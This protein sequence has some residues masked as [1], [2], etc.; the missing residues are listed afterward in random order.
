MRS[1]FLLAAALTSIVSAQTTMETTGHVPAQTT[2]STTVVSV[3]EAASELSR[4]PLKNVAASLINVNAVMTT[5][6]IGCAPGAEQS[7]CEIKNSA[8]LVQ[9]PSTWSLAGTYTAQTLGESVTVTVD[10]AC[11]LGGTT[12]A[13][14]SFSYDEQA[15]LNGESTST[16]SVVQTSYTA[17]QITF[18]PL[19]VT[20]GVSKFYGPQATQTPTGA[21]VAPRATGIPLAAAAM[22]AAAVGF[23]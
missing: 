20:A 16:S 2:A 13:S 7:A 11:S 9:G 14:C 15:T 19:T 12:T 1:T 3:F 22:A 18:A 8:T 10:E 4:F 21:A 6:A 17:D 23:L 5:Y